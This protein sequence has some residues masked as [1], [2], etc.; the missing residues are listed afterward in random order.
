MADWLFEAGAWAASGH[1]VNEHHIGDGNI[2]YRQACKLGREGIVSL[3]SVYRSG[4]AIL[5]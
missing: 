3:G 1:P 4:R 2:V 5:C